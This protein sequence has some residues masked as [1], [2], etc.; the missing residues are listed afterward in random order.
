MVFTVLAFVAVGMFQL[1]HSLPGGERGL[2][3]FERAC[4][5]HSSSQ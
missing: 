5:I 4:P 3:L 1:V 2:L